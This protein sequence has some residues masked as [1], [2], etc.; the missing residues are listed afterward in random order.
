MMYYVVTSNENQMI[1][2]QVKDVRSEKS[3][4]CMGSSRRHWNVSSFMSCNVK[5]RFRLGCTGSV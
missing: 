4:Y 5:R 3:N 1:I 2:A